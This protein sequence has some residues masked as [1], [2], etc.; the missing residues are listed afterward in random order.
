V[1]GAQLEEALVARGALEV[2]GAVGVSL[3]GYRALMLACNGRVK[4]RA[5]ASLAGFVGLSAEERAQL[6]QFAQLARTRTVPVGLVVQQFL[7]PA[8]R[9]SHPSIDRQVEA[10]PA[11]ID[12][13]SLADELDAGAMC[14]DLGARIASLAIPILARVGDM[15][16]AVPPAH[17]EAIRSAARHC[18]L[19]VVP[20]VGHLL[21]VEDAEGT[22]QA[23]ESF[24][25]GT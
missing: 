13:D 8:F 5:V 1:D 11:S 12:P 6:K 2:A 24:L 10:W 21:L 23:V 16:V 4:V 19:Q 14:E 22:Q 18:E 15:D 3:G 9:A 25:A 7:S 20:G 17:S